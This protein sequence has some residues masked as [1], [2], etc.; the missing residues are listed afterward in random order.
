MAAPG[1]DYTLQET[2]EGQLTCSFPR[3]PTGIT[4]QR[5]WVFDMVN[6]RS[7]AEVSDLST[8]PRSTH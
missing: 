6:S 8:D 7:T 1:G 4:T 3:V 2:P 5:C